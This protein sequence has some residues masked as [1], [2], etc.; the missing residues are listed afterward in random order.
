M[1]LE[2][3]G[4]I[5]E[6]STNIKF[7]QNQCSGSRVIPYG[8]TRRQTDRRTDK[9]KLIVPFCNFAKALESELFLAMALNRGNTWI[10]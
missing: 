7:H 6:E 2:F 5:F 3:S 10:W 9:T 4:Q 8:R 1:K